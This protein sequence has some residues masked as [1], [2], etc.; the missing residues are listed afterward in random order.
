[1]VRFAAIAFLLAHGVAWAQGEHPWVGVA[2]KAEAES[3]FTNIKS[4]DIVE[5][6]VVLKFGMRNYGIAPA[7]H[8]VN[9]RGTGHHHLL[10]DTPLPSSI[11]NPIPFS[12]KYMHFGR[13]Q[14][15]A[16]LNLPP[17]HHT[18]RL[19][20]ADYE[21]VPYF[22]FSPEISFTV[23]RYNPAALPAD[24][25]KQARLEL[26]NL[27]NGANLYSPFL[28]QFHASALNVSHADT[29]MPNTGYFQVRFRR[30]DG[31]RDTPV[32]IP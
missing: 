29:K 5:S 8:K 16:I 28:L 12:D 6:P 11:T 26:L 9:I 2:F 31:P 19:L 23:S 10:I 3:Y 24:Y 25:G 7:G 22:V 20:M 14:M 17:G 4:G 32:D 15:E 1:M 30:L 27:A 21:H 13:G 18:V